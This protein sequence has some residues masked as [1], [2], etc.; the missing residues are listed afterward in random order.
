MSPDRISVEGI[1][2]TFHIEG[3]KTER[4]GNRQ[5]NVWYE[6]SGG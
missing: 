2:R 3:L 5:W 1:G 4:S 6:D